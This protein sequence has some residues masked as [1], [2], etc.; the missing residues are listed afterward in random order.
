[1][2]NTREERFL[3][4]VAG[5]RGETGGHRVAGVIIQHSTKNLRERFQFSP[6]SDRL[7]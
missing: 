4:F 2:A 3:V 7:D 6:A 1:M 5:G